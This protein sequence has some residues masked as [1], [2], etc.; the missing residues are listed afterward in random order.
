MNTANKTTQ[1]MVI[2]TQTRLMDIT[3]DE[4][5]KNICVQITLLDVAKP[6]ITKLEF[7]GVSDS[8][9]KSLIIRC[10]YKF[11]KNEIV[12]KILDQ[13]NYS[14]IE[15]AKFVLEEDFDTFVQKNFWPDF[16]WYNTP[17]CKASIYL[18]QTDGRV[19]CDIESSIEDI[20]YYQAILKYEVS[21]SYIEEVIN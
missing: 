1:A 10:D 11:I 15:H 13:N 9:W 14:Y 20:A 17:L 5:T 2:I 4:E 6:Y 18:K 19:L 12:K 8:Y 7:N 3:F 16:N 21:S